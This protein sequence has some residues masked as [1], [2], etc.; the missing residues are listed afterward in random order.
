MSNGRKGREERRGCLLPPVS[1]AK[2]QSRSHRGPCRA[3]PSGW[4]T[5]LEGTAFVTMRVDVSACTL[6]ACA[7]VAGSDA[8][9]DVRH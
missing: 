6:S 8:A 1:R 4:C 2:K 9:T 5:E 7:P 3:V